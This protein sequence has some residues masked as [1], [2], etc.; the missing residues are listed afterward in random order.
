MTSRFSMTFV[1]LL[2]CLALAATAFADPVLVV[3]VT[4][5]TKGGAG[6]MA[7]Y[8]GDATPLPVGA[9]VV[10]SSPNAGVTSLATG[11]WSGFNSFQITSLG[12]T[13]TPAATDDPSVLQVVVGNETSNWAEVAF[14]LEEDR[15]DGTVFDIPAIYDLTVDARDLEFTSTGSNPDKRWD[16]IYYV[17]P[18]PTTLILSVVGL[19]GLLAFGRRMR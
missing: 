2:A 19:C 7:I 1:T 12:L 10:D 14:G 15:A 16:T 8:V 6:H 17:I 9:I 3:D 5:V 13:L 4:D 11:D 18:E